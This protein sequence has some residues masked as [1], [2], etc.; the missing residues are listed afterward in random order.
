MENA[1]SV[2]LQDAPEWYKMRNDAA[3]HFALR[4]CV[5]CN[6]E[7]LEEVAA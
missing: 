5:L 1:E 6:G 3:R 7:I 4:Y 2:S